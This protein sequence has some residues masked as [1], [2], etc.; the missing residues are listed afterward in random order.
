MLFS[1]LYCL[2]GIEWTYED[3]GAESGVVSIG[4]AVDE[5]VQRVAAL[6]IIIN[7]CR[8]SVLR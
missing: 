6:D 2:K 1:I 4:Q 8:W 5:G 7:S 3:N